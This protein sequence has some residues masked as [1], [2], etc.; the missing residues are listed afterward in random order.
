MIIIKHKPIP[1]DVQI[2]TNRELSVNKPNMVVKDHANQCYKI[3]CVSVPY[4]Q[5]TSTKVIEELLKYKDLE[6]ETTRR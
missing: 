5:N 6:S 3:I 4:N 2:H 1:W